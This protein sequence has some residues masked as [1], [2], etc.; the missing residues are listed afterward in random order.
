MGYAID[1]TRNSAGQ[2]ADVIWDL[3]H[4]RIKPLSFDEKYEVGKR[5]TFSRDNWE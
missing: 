5:I 2:T 3:L 1:T 4:K